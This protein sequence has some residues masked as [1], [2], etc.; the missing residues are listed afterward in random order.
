MQG[1]ASVRQALFT[2]HCCDL[3]DYVDM[4]C[5]VEKFKLAYVGL[6][7]TITDKSQW[8]ESNHAFFLYPPL[9]K[10]VAGRRK[11]KRFKGSTEGEEHKLREGIG[12]PSTN[13]LDITRIPAKM[14]TLLMLQLT[15][16]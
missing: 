12:A 16:L 11:T 8:P 7:L 2:C 1:M 5:S 14:V 9:L 15:R 10:S 6:I 3:E 13:N 4:Y